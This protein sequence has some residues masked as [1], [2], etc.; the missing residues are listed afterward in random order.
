MAS[1]TG[2]LHVLQCPVIGGSSPG[3][4]RPLIF[5][6]FVWTVDARTTTSQ[7][8]PS[9]NSAAHLHDIEA[10]D[11]NPALSIADVAVTDRFFPLGQ[12]SSHRKIDQISTS[13]VGS[14]V[15]KIGRNSSARGRNSSPYLDGKLK[16][17][18]LRIRSRFRSEMRLRR[19]SWRIRGKPSSEIREDPGV[20][21]HDSEARKKDVQAREVVVK[22]TED[23]PAPFTPNIDNSDGLSD[24]GSATE[25]ES[26]PGV[27]IRFGEAR[28]AQNSPQPSLRC[29]Y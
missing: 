2:S 25:S 9:F 16:T 21:I 10:A 28:S 4:C 12:S 7:F 8:S 13:D 17:A 1:I 15:S 19:N 18:V 5:S 27:R 23:S 11:Q 29:G 20:G 14:G 3:R 6:R 24:R 22:G 26:N